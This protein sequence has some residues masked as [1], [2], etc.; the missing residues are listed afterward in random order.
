M[1]PRGPYIV[2]TECTLLLA[3]GFDFTGAA[4]QPAETSPDG[5]TTW[6]PIESS[7]ATGQFSICVE[8]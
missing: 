6:Y 2:S 5:G 8:P 3:G 7:S 1:V 4:D